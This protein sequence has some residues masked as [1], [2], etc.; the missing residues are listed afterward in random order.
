[1]ELNQSFF[2][3]E[4]RCNFLITNKRKK[5]WHIEIQLLQ[6]FDEFCQ[7]HNLRYFVE[8][9]TLLGA[10]RHQGFIPWDDDID[11]VMFRDDYEKLQEIAP[12][13]FTYPYFFQNSYN[14]LVLWPFAKIRDSR[15]TAIEY[16]DAPLE[17]NQGIFID[18]FPLDDVPDGRAFSPNILTIQFE[19]W[20]TVMKPEMVLQSLE[21]G[22]T[23]TI[24][25]DILTDLL[26][27]PLR[28]RLQQFE[29]FN[30]SHF[31]T[32]EN[33]NFLMEELRDN[34]TSRKKEWYSE[35][36]YLPFEYISVPAPIGYDQILKCQYGDYNKLVQNGSCH[37]NIF[38]DPDT[39]YLHYIN[40]RE[41]MQ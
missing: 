4:V 11:V 27:L 39:P 22:N 14:D 35:T 26:N 40:H 29:T 12:S 7:K 34:S 33:T 13:E 5:I 20:L 25:T 16:R 9:G 30:L 6:K 3:E 31:G 37:E 1:M 23:F 2:Q 18:I 17:L 8:Y 24:G 28:D 19:L 38:I 36:V 10:V 15:T 41:E 32:S 21:Q